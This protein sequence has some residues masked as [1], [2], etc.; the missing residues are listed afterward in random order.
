MTQST[1]SRAE[2]ISRRLVGS[3]WVGIDPITI[4]TIVA[5]LIQLIMKCVQPNPTP[6]PAMMLKEK[7]AKHRNED[8]TY[9]SRFLRQTKRQAYLAGRR[10][11]QRL[12]DEQQEQ[13]A[14]SAFEEAMTAPEGEVDTAVHDAI[15][16]AD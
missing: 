6:S 3:A 1:Q 9:D 16:E 7:I 13:M 4:I 8:G 5:T 15:N 12:T 11:G 10:H 2:G 14:L